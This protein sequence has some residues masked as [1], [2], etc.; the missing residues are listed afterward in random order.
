VEFQ[1]E[2]TSKVADEKRLSHE[3]IDSISTS[4]EKLCLH[5]EGFVKEIPQAKVLEPVISPL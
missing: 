5:E 4:L 3:A 2:I 1:K